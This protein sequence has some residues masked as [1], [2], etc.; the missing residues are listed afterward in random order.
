M[1]TLRIFLLPALMLCCLSASAAKPKK[2]SK[3]EK[4]PE[5]VVD[6]VSIDEFS[7]H[8]GRANTNGL[9]QYLAQRMGIDVTYMEDFIKGFNQGSLTEQDKREKARLAGME[10]RQQVEEQVIPQAASAIDEETDK[11]N[12]AKFLEGFRAGILETEV[13]GISM[14]ST[15][16]IVQKNIEY[17]HTAQMEAKYGE[18][19]KAGEDFLAKN[20]K[21]KDVK[22][23]ESGLQYKILT[24]G[25]GAIPTAEQKV[26]VHYRGTLLDGTEFDS[27]YKRNE[28]ATFGC[29][30]VIAGWTE[31]L[32]MMP[33]GSK[34]MLYI[35]YQL[36]YGD[37]ETGSIQPF[38]MLT[39]EVELLSIE[40]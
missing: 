5:V 8:F 13:P 35:P 29:N 24:K 37:R 38:S 3:K 20:A 19:R 14:D 27:S 36:A 12:H 18:N 10:I 4:E 30:Q 17:Y 39:F 32:T 2:K 16:V 31:A 26:K 23:T 11:L 22:V 1:K 33:V 7:F 15:Q 40:E 25:T 21:E 34:W 9:K 6:T 28:P